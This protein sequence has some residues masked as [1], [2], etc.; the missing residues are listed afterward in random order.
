[1]KLL[2]QDKKGVMKMIRGMGHLFHEVRLMKLGLF[3]LQKKW[4]QG[5]AIDA[6]Q[7]LTEDYKQDT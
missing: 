2:E 1:M 4:F 5:D 3:S 6:F 7:Y